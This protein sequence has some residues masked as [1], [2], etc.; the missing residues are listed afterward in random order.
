MGLLG[1]GRRAATPVVEG[2]GA[3]PDGAATVVAGQGAGP[4]AWAGDEFGTIAADQPGSRQQY[5]K[6][7]ERT[8]ARAPVGRE[9]VRDD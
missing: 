9:G 3:D 1:L 8:E 5:L 2:D 7:T 4:A 6:K